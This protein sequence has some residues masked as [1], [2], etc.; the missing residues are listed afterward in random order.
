MNL[1][2]TITTNK[3]CELVV[4]DNT[5]YSTI[6]VATAISFSRKDV[7]PVVLLT[8]RHNNISSYIGDNKSS[9]L[10]LKSIPD[11]YFDVEYYLI[12]TESYYETS[13]QKYYV[14]DGNLC[15]P[16][17]SHSGG[18]EIVD[19]IILSQNNSKLYKV[20]LVGVSIC[21]LRK[22]YVNLCNQIFNQQGISSCYNKT[23]IDTQLIHNR[24]ILLMALNIIR[25]LAESV[26]NFEEIHRII[27]QLNGCNS[28]CKPTRAYEKRSSCRCS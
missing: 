23:N 12:P 20:T 6:P 10:K 14:K 15:T 16:N 19:P 11:G 9:V 22:C 3:N 26:N 2:I 18:I 13:G 24:D 7:I 25:Y 21:F 4:K 17:P 8:D 5:E 27:D 1:N 28:F